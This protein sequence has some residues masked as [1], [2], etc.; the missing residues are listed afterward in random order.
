MRSRGDTRP[1]GP[2]LRPPQPAG[3]SPRAAGVLAVLA[4]LTALAPLSVDIYTPSLPQI[5]RDLGGADWL[6]QASITSCLLGIGVGQLVWG[7]LSDRAGRRRIVLLGVVGWTLTSV[8]SAVA[9]TPLALVAARA[10][11]GLCGAAGIVVARSIVRDISPELR[12]M[13]ARI[14]MLSMVTAVAPVV[15]PIAGAAIAVAWGWRGDFFALAALGGA[16]VLAFALVVPE[17]LPRQERAAPRRFGL[18]SDLAAALRDREL[19][20]VGLA[21]AAH[22]FGFYAYVATASFVVERELGHPPVVFALVFGTN[23]AAMFGANLAFR[24]IVR[25]RHPALPLGIGLAVSAA[26]GL[27]LC[28]VALT[29]GPEWLLWLSSTAFAA[30][31]GFVI[32]GAHSWGQATPVASGSASAVTGSAQFLGG[33]LGSPVTGLLGPTAAHLGLVIAVGSAAGLLAWATVRRRSG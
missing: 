8:L 7:P 13:S 25:S 1:R 2:R 20:H 18:V 26:S 16:I 23:A 10:L 12:V 21:L 32:P 24:R 33:V 28:L 3:A 17:T 11:A 15:A 27:A 4:I 9:A 19:A 6:A 22:A 31:A 5:Q 30:S 14:G 29:A